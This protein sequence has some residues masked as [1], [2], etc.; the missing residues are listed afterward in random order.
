MEQFKTLEDLR[1][2]LGKLERW[3]GRPIVVGEHPTLFL[4]E[5][6]GGREVICGIQRDDYLFSTDGNWILPSREHGLSFSA[7]WQHLK[8]IYRMKSKRN[9]DKAVSVYWILEKAD[10]PDGLEFVPDPRDRQRQHYLLAAVQGMRVTELRAKLEWVADRM[11]V[12]RDAQVA[13]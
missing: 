9:P 13:L 12:I 11:S 2:Y 1:V 5:A 3:F 4:N 7:H 8:G 6:G 10:I